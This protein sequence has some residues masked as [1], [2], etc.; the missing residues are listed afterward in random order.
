MVLEGTLRRR[1]PPPKPCGRSRPS[2]GLKK[3][4]NDTTSDASIVGRMKIVQGGL[5]DP[6]VQ[7]LLAL[8]LRTAREETA[9]GSARALDLTGL[10]SAEVTFYSAWDGGRLVGVGA[11]K[12]LPPAQGEVKSM[13]T[14]QS[15]RRAGVG[16]AILRHIIHAAQDMGMIR[17]SLETG[18]WAYFEPARA[19]YRKHGFLEC[20]PFGDYVED[21]N[22]I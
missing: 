13:H 3:A 15:E 22:S 10:R 11:L 8:H 16:S 12:R 6:R 21:P 5:D 2:A 4:R 9:P 19:L 20:G 17:L 18:S 14:I 7:D 1:C